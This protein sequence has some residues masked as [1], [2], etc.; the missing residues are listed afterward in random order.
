VTPQEIAD[1]ASMRPRRAPR[2]CICMRAN[3]KT[4][5]PDQS[6]EAFR[7]VPENHQAAFPTA[8]IN[9]TTGG[10]PT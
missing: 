7:T 9:L 5:Q 6:P 4:G 10:A 8:L 2:S 1:A 3:P